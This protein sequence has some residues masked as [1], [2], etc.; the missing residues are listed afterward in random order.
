MR[1]ELSLYIYKTN[2][3][4]K[5]FR[6]RFVLCKEA[7]EQLSP[8]YFSFFL[9][10]INLLMFQ[11]PFY[12]ITIHTRCSSSGVNN[13]IRENFPAGNVVSHIGGGLDGKIILHCR[14]FIKAYAMTTVVSS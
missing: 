14:V 5:L 6:V 9:S 4:F 2:G 8:G 10:I 7:I 11:I 12:L 13:H 3:V 1:L